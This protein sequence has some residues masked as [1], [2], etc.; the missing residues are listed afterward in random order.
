[1]N[2]CDKD[3]EEI[4][5]EGRNCPCCDI[6]KE[7]EKV[8]CDLDNKQKEVAELSAALEDSEYKVAWYKDMITPEVLKK[9]PELLEPFL[10]KGVK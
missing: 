9:S 7:K 4:C 6:I 1:M 3:H 10:M 2:L 8:E 5:Y